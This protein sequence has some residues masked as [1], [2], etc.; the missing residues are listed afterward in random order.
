MEQ[1]LV[2]E[3]ELQAPNQTENQKLT[4]WENEPTLQ[5]LKNDL[6]TSKS[7]HD[8]QLAKMARWA[9]LL[10]VTGSAKPPK[11]RGRSS[12]QPK[13]VRKQAEWRYSALSEPFL[14]TE[15]IFKVYPRTF[16]DEDAA[17]Q[18]SLLL[19]WQFNTKLNK[20]RF[21][22]DYVR[23]IV[24][25]GTGI[26]KLGWYRQTKMVSKEEPVFDY[27]PIDPMDPEAERQLQM[28]QEATALASQDPRTFEQQTDPAIKAAVAFSQESGTPVIATQVGTTIT[29]EE[30]PVVNEPYVEVL[31]PSNVYIDPTCNGDFT[32]ALF[33][34]HAF[35]TNKAE[36]SQ[37]PGR[38]HNLDQVNWEDASPVSDGEYV[39]NTSATS[40]NFADKTRKKIIAY[41][42][43]GYY[44][45]HNDG[46]LVPFVATWI[47]N[48][49]IRMEEN[50]FP[51]E[52]L[53]FVLV[54]YLP[55]KRDVYGEPDA[56][57]LE[58]N[59]R[60]LGAITRG[61]IDS[62]GRSANA[63]QGFAKGMLDP[64]NRRRFENGEDY[65]FNPT[66]NPQAGGYIEH[67]YPELPQSA[68]LMV[69]MQN[70]E[71]E[72]LTGVK[73]FSGGLAGDAYNSKV[74]TAIRGVL[75]ASAKREMSILRRLAKGIC[76]IGEKII[77]MNGEFLSDKEVI[78]VTNKQYTTVNREDLKGNFD[79]EVDI[80]TAEVD[81]EKAQD[82]GFML[83][84]LGPNMDPKIT[85]MILAEIADLKRMPSLAEK[86]RTYEPQPDP[87]QEQ[88]K[89]L[90][91]AKLQAEVQK[92]QAEVQKIQAE[93]GLQGAKA[94]I[95]AANAQ[96]NA[97]KL[98]SEMEKSA[99]DAD[100]TRAKADNERL[101][102]ALE[103]NGTAH[104]QEMEKM[105]AQ[106]QG[107]Q[108]LE[109]TKALLKPRKA[110]ETRPD[111][112]SAIGFNAL[113]E[114]LADTAHNI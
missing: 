32:K 17:K 109:V 111:V 59:Q 14:S 70:Q 30:V 28:L 8:A 99:A 77:A 81:N 5:S 93:A 10:N 113:S 29:Q 24:D 60:I 51:D 50:P 75:D 84:T 87:M 63:Q 52:K 85:M 4:D 78:R 15:N 62:L 55:V 103:A 12:V 9:D 39:S 68:M 16:E 31:N 110:E 27:Y 58:E 82:L 3:A 44:D 108:N 47:G 40:E 105:R 57:L 73:A 96:T 95:E 42:Y 43:W 104:A 18:N 79:L 67:Q 97:Y 49:L 13:L 2:K 41:E 102:F 83:Q 64:L 19:N 98:Q 33:I 101:K 46:T 7:S 76:Q 72:S 37:I 34:V 91:L 21:I 107:N 61:M 56:E 89:Q 92:L 6:L 26:V 1:P 100:L 36:L 35:E 80:A 106:A 65:E 71:A 48:V 66:I 86:L 22:D 90:E 74:A 88:A 38:Y 69:Q 11:R 20:V 25:E 54:Q 53:P 112:E 45:I 94:E 23:S 114:R